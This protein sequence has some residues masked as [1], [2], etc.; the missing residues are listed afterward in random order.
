MLHECRVAHCF[1]WERVIRDVEFDGDIY[2]KSDES[3]CLTKLGQI[4]KSKF[5]F[6]NTY[7][8]MYCLTIPSIVIYIDVRLLEVPKIAF[9]KSD[10]INIIWFLGHCTEKKM[11]V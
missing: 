4:K 8:A 9:Q 10:V 3:Q 5:A 2:F 7:L 11:L 6:K 1:I